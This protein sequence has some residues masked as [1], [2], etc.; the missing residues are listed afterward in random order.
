MTPNYRARPA[1]P[2]DD[3]AIE[4][5]TRAFL[6]RRNGRVVRLIA[7]K[8]YGFIRPA[9]G[10]EECFFHSTECPDFEALSVGAVVSFVLIQT[11]RGPRAEYVS[12]VSIGDR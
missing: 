9:N 10:G 5:R 4:H 2:V 7:A 11:R 8:G 6:P 1:T 12:I 3:S